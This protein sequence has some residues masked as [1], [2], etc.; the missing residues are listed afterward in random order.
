M[1]FERIFYMRDEDDDF[2]DGGTYGDSLEED[3]EEE[4]DEEE[5]EATTTVVEDVEPEDEEEHSM[6][7]PVARKQSKPASKPSGTTTPAR[8]KAP[9]KKKAA[10]KKSA[11]KKK[12]AKKASK[13]KLLL[14]RRPQRRRL[15]RRKPQRKNDARSFLKTPVP[16]NALVKLR[17]LFLDGYTQ[18][19]ACGRRGSS[20]QRSDIQEIIDSIRFDRQNSAT[21][22]VVVLVSY[23][24]SP[25]YFAPQPKLPIN[26]GLKSAASIFAS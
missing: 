22:A 6:P 2:S 24:P 21:C 25:S 16:T 1:S 3:F 4:E 20:G 18:S 7:T 13:K 17:H 12:V 9:A 5:P 11:L 8:K 15:L 14:K 26:P 19:R 23:W 10:K